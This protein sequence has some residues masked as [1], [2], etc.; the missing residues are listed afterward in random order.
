MK[1]DTWKFLAALGILTAIT[2][3]MLVLFFTRFSLADA[4][5]GDG[6]LVWVLCN[7]KSFV[8]IRTGPSGRSEIGGRAEC[9]DRYFT[10]GTKRKGFV[11]VDAPIE[12]G[13]GWISDRYIVYTEPVY[14]GKVCRIQSK[15]RVA[16][17]EYIGGDR[18]RWLNDGD[19]VTVYWMAEW[20]VT[21]KGFIQSEFIGD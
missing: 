13:D 9:G 21:N 20:A 18:T 15:G 14:V 5:G 17:R 16:C 1:K 3:G 12:A 6:E 7:P 19:E 8:N 10:D 11:H 4:I 2:V